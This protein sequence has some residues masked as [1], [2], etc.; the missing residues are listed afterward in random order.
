L[1]DLVDSAFGL[2]DIEREYIL[3]NLPPRDPLSVI[4]GAVDTETCPQTYLNL[5]AGFPG[6]SNPKKTGILAFGSLITDSGPELQSKIVTRIKTKT[7]FPVEY[8]RIS[9]TR[10]GAPT[11]VPHES[12]A[13]VLAEI[14]VLDDSLSVADATDML[15]RRERRR[16]GT[17]ETYNRGSGENS[18]LVEEFHDNPCVS[19]ALYTDFNPSGKIPRPIAADLAKQ[20]IASVTEAPEGRDGITYLMDAIR[21]GIETP[22]T[23]DYRAEILKQTMTLTLEEALKTAKDGR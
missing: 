16:E 11:L 4:A 21:S 23:A 19:T 20:A 7:P 18:V 17:D 3:R 13:P 6:R 5:P 8:A 2:S 15:W 9:R 22:L 14:L 12:G 1:S 10:G